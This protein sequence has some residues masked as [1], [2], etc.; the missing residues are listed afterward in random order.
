MKRDSM[1]DQGL[2]HAGTVLLQCLTA[3]SRVYSLV[4]NLLAE[5]Y[6]ESA[7]D[8]FIIGIGFSL[9]DSYFLS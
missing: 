7:K 9:W 6:Y 4:S 5:I 8:F 2:T 3:A 1:D